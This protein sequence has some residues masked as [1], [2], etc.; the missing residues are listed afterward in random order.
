MSGFLSVNGIV[1]RFGA[2]TALAGI[3]LQVAQG[4][5]MCL[6]GPSGCGKTTLLRV[7]AGLERQDMGTVLVE[8]RDVSR[9]PPAQR[10]TGSSSRAMHC[11]PTS[12]WRR[13]S[14]T[15]SARAGRSAAAGWRSCW[16]WWG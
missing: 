4:E 5:F 12:R 9:L 1:K 3:D 2:F 13:T 6:L 15:G 10:D 8:G 7:I 14:A 11:S 16:P